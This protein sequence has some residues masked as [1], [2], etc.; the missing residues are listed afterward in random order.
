METPVNWVAADRCGNTATCSSVLTVEDVPPSI[1]PCSFDRCIWPPNHDYVCFDN[2]SL[3]ATVVEECGDPTATVRVLCESSQCDD[4]PCP[5]HPGEDGDGVTINDCTY[6]PVLDRVCVRSERAG[7]DPRGRYYTI[8][9]QAI[10][11][12][13]AGQPSVG[14]RFWIPHDQDQ[15]PHHCIVSDANFQGGSDPDVVREEYET[16]GERK[17]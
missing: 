4:A 13:G 10:D 16:S 6:D 12:C 11:S 14:L 3:Q 8:S 17:R 9:F 1:L 2:V 15:A 5:E 7:S